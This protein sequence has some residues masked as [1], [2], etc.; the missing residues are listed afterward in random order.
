MPI[1]SRSARTHPTTLSWR[2]GW[3]VASAEAT[4]AVVA[5]LSTGGLYRKPLKLN[6]KYADNERRQFDDFVHSALPKRSGRNRLGLSLLYLVRSK[7]RPFGCAVGGRICRA[8]AV[9]PRML[10]IRRWDYSS[11]SDTCTPYLRC[12]IV[13]QENPRKVNGLNAMPKQRLPICTM[14]PFHQVPY[15]VETQLY[16]YKT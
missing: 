8:R 15:V 6:D 12:S 5:A 3:A 13:S 2:P 7:S 16:L 9:K 10:H 11:F 1:L 4:K 14:V